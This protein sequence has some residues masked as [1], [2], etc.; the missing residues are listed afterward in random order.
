MMATSC[1]LWLACLALLGWASHA[2]AFSDP[3]TFSD[4]TP[5]GGGGG[6]YFTGS[7]A[8]GFGCNVCHQGGARAA[9]TIT[10]LPLA[11][12]RPGAAYEVR[13]DWPASLEHLGIELEIT[14]S[15]GHG[16]GELRLPPASEL[17]NE[18][19][20]EPV[21]DGFGAGELTELEQRTVLSVV[22]CGAKRLRFLWV[23]P[24]E[25]R[26]SLRFSGGLVASDGEADAAG[27]GVTMF[28]H[29]LPVARGGA[30]PATEISGG[31]AVRAVRASSAGELAGLGLL[32][33]ALRLRRRAR[34]G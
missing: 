4:P 20:C 8:D 25:A 9:A 13:L 28:A 11:G 5:M 21:E 17:P 16:A 1:G 3:L 26:G 19:R 10:G 33:M 6:R 30:V 15:A 31:C 12:Y 29:T 2:R 22:D 7:A 24:S 34:L 32:L 14:D 18:E 27:D 23:A